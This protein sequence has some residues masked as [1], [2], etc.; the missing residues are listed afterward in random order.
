MLMKDTTIHPR[1][2]NFGMWEYLE[3]EVDDRG[4]VPKIIVNCI[5]R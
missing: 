1:C 3:E 2:S 4:G 5:I